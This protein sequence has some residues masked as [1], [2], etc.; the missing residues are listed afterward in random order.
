MK[1]Q[2]S[3]KCFLFD[4]KTVMDERGSLSSLEANLD[5]PFEIKRIFYMHHVVSDR[6]GHAHTDTDQVII[7]MSGTVKISLFD[8]EKT[9]EYVLDDCTKGLFVPR[10]TFTDLYG[11]TPGAVCLVLA[12][13][14]YDMKKSLRNRHDY[15]DYLKHNPYE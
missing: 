1:Q 4:I 8:G 9:E 15:L 14:H 12:N 7:A 6:G 10:L 13:T 11:F 3:M 2:S 5:I